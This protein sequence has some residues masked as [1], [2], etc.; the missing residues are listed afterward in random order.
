MTITASGF[1]LAPWQLEAVEVWSA[2]RGGEQFKGTLEVFTGGGKTLIALRCI[3]VASELS[4]DLRVAIVVPTKALAQQWS[5]VVG[6]HTGIPPDQIGLLGA[7]GKSTLSRCRVLVTVLNTAAK[8]LPEM[9]HG[10]QPL[11][12]VVDEC[13]R[14]GAPSFSRVLNTQAEYRLGL[15]ATPER[16]E[17]DDDGEPLLFDEQLVGRKLGPVLFRFSLKDAR[18]HGWL[19]EYVL[20]HHGLG[21]EDD[22]KR[23][24]ETISRRVDD[25]GDEL[26]DLGGDTSRAYVL[27]RRKD[28][29]GSAAKSYIAATAK[30]K[31]LLYRARQR[32]RIAARLVA[33]SFLDRPRRVLLF[34]ERVD[35]AVA[36]YEEIKTMPALKNV[37]IRLEH[38]RL[39]VRERGEAL[40]AFRTGEASVLVSVKSLIEGID[41]PE[42][43]V[44]IS[45]ASNSSV[46]QRVQSLG[47][48]LRRQ[49]DPD[50]E[51]K[52]AEMHLLYMADTVD[53]LIYGKEDWGDLTGEGANRYLRWSLDPEVGPDLQPGPP[54]SPRPTEEQE[55]QRFG[56]RPPATP[57]KWLGV[58][59]G[60]EYSIDTM[61]TVTNSSGV[62]IAN[63]QGSAAMVTAVRGRPGGR[64]RVTPIY[65]MVLVMRDA[66]DGIE[67][68]VAGALGDPFVAI[69]D[70][71][72]TA[73]PGDLNLLR[74]GD[75]YAG[76]SDKRGG[77]YQL[78]QKNGG[79][80]ER[81]G[82]NRTSEWAF[83]EGAGHSDLEENATRVLEAWR[84]T[85]DRGITFYVNER[86]DAWYTDG[87][88]RLFLAHV[89]GGFA[90]PTG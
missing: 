49:F 85:F 52:R 39:P 46:R 21:L 73:E 42:A 22:E 70:D 2:G 53:D 86:G 76:S 33:E 75:R 28:D 78:R 55:W 64:F 72:P 30:R 58:L 84:S 34:H 66:A 79:V 41:V 74:P 50:A 51:V 9:S 67:A 13:H 61:E 60:Q 10:N 23:R 90:W 54:R 31:D 20:N 3:Q 29:V 65:H 45:V 81:K 43:D 48:V 69:A 89:P 62:I 26:R 11:M 24:Y 16:E 59:V 25:L 56:L 82:P 36:L 35:E 5:D 57:E 47:R 32:N 63:P 83:T 18:A 80:I 7:G 8:R 1:D 77:T 27:Q 4:P 40:A 15:S 87:G 71:S 6:K 68:M 19:P 37:G 88:V 17:L 12:L 14:A 44:G 38:S